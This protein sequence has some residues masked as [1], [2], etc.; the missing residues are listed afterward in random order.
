MKRKRD[1]CRCLN[2]LSGSL[3]CTYKEVGKEFGI[4]SSRVGQI[5]QFTFRWLRDRSR[6]GRNTYSNWGIK[7]MREN[8]GLVMEAIIEQRNNLG[9]LHIHITS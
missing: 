9:I 8:K 4:S 2:I 1:I 3:S 5:V 7:E 6:Y